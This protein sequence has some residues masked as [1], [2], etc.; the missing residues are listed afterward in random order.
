MII[1]DEHT[2]PDQRHILRLWRLKV[3]HIGSDIGRKG[4]QDEEI[5]PLL[6]ALR[7]PTFFTLDAGFYRRELCHERYCIAH[8]TVTQQ[9]I[10]VFVR[11]FLRHPEFDA[12]ARR[13]GA[14]VHIAHPG[15]SVWRLGDPREGHLDWPR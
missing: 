5:I 10:A 1:L 11:R 8:L 13:M 4:M 2:P 9:E 7:T 15:L 6:H 3:R 14:V 12:L